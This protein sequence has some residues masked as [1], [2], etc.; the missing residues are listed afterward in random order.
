MTSARNGLHGMRS[1]YNKYISFGKQSMVRAKD[2]EEWIE[3]DGST[4]Q[5]LV[6]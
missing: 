3:C 5:S 2:V 4:D 1:I 6:F